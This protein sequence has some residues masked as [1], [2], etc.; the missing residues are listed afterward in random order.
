MSRRA[1]WIVIAVLAGFSSVYALA[2]PSGVLLAGPMF[3][4]QLPY[5]LLVA[6]PHE[7]TEGII[8][9]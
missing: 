6:G 9:A 4:M 3:A 2:A 8:Q 1:R 7:V 5:V